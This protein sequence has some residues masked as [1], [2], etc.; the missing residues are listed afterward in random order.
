MN[1]RLTIQ[2]MAGLLAE[3]TGKDKKETERFLRV[4]V[5]VV[6]DGVFTD[7]SVKIKGLGTFKIIAVEKR[8]SIHVNTGKRF[9]IPEHYKFSFLPDKE[10]KELVNKPFSFFETT[11]VNENVDFSDTDQSNDD[12]SDRE[13]E[14]E[15]VEEIIPEERIIDEK[16][17]TTPSESVVDILQKEEQIIETSQESLEEVVVEKKEE[18]QEEQQKTPEAEVPPIEP[19]EDVSGSEKRVNE[20]ADYPDY[21]FQEVMREDY[22][23]NEHSF[24]KRMIIVL[25]TFVLVGI[26]GVYL[27]FDFKPFF[28]YN[29]S[30]G[31]SSSEIEQKEEP[32]NAILS[33]SLD[34]AVVDYNDTLDVTSADTMTE[35]IEIPEKESVKIKETVQATAKPAKNDLVKVK[36][37]AGDRLTLIALEHYGHKIFWVYLYEHN[38]NV[39]ADPNNVP[40]G[41]EIV[42]PLAEL[43]GIDAHSS[44]SIAKAAALQTQILSGGK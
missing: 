35:K 33:D 24:L 20:Y 12:D 37:K 42:I 16:F 22:D 11:E 34:M 7:K 43:Y 6:M 29:Y 40:V 8:E 36:I 32:G 23:R 18:Q 21:S 39:I 26:V 44:T 15:S 38:K 4:L 1:S 25:F 30:N 3:Y 2:D 31:N 41:T 19:I 14:D 13:A 5:S 28:T 27:F 17:P 10:L 9:L